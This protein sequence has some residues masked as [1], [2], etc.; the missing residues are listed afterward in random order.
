M[1]KAYSES[2]KKTIEHRRRQRNELITPETWEMIAERRDLKKKT[3][4]AKSQRSKQK[5]EEQYLEELA[6]ATEKVAASSWQGKVY[7]ITNLICGR[8]FKSNIH[9][10]DIQGN[11]LT[12]EK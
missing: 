9:I 7:K 10:K 3:T 8:K 12:T 4:D 6:S 11:L 2:S 1:V 5:L